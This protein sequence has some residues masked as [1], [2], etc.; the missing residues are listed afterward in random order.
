ML[1]GGS[2]TILSLLCVLLSAMLSMELAVV[3]LES[4]ISHGMFSATSEPLYAVLARYE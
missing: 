3:A 1:P 4:H 2:G